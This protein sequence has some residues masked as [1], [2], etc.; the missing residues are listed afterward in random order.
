[1]TQ[2]KNSLLLDRYNGKTGEHS[3]YEG[4][5]KTKTA[6]GSEPL[7]YNDQVRGMI[8]NIG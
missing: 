4:Q 5:Q 6:K 7:L 8:T 3:C 1:M 2:Q